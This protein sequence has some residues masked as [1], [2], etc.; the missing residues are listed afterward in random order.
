MITVCPL[1]SILGVA[2]I[3]AFYFRHPAAEETNNHMLPGRVGEWYVAM[4]QA[5]DLEVQAKLV[6]QRCDAKNAVVA[7]V[8]AGRLTLLEAAARFRSLNAS[9]P[10]A[11]QWL[12]YKFRDQSYE[13]ALCRS[14]INRVEVE[15]RSRASQ[16]EYDTVARLESELAEHLQRH[17]R[18]CLPD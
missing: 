18:I 13:L 17:G 1:A 15:L 6:Q 3:M 11:K 2:A 10:Q 9:C 16:Q 4:I 8:I 12:S 5:Q 7:D 14:I